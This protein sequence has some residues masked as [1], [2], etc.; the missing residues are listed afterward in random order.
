V[1]IRRK[2]RIWREDGL[3]V[4]R[5]R[6]KRQRLDESTVPADRLR[7]T[8][9][10]RRFS[11]GSDRRRAQPQAAAR[12]RRITREALPIQ[13]QRRIDADTTVSVLERLVA[14]RGAAAGFVRCDNGPEMTANALRDWCRFSGR[15]RIN[16]AGLT[17]AEPLRRELRRPC[18][19]RA[20]GRRDVL[21]P[22]ARRR[23]SSR[24]GASTTTTTAYTAR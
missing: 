10:G 13:C 3:R 22:E 7:P 1:S 15:Q 20:V 16:R 24:T 4:P 21:L 5:K 18:P 23:S 6:R 14:D 19:R 9:C 8:T 2:G 11:M 17:V 12:R